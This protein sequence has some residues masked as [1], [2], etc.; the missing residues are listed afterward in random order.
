MT[1]RT[2]RYTEDNTE[3]FTQ[4]GLDTLNE[5]YNQIIAMIGHEDEQIASSVGDLLNNAW[6]EGITA[7]ELVRKV[8]PAFV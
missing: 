2:I 3:G 1:N 7:D 8:A 6:I 5:A 4:A